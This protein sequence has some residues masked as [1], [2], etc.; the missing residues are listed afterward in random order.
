[1]VCRSFL[2]SSKA[3][4]YFKRPKGSYLA[5]PCLH[6][7]LSSPTH[8]LGLAIR[9]ESKALDLFAGNVKAVLEENEFGSLHS[10]IFHQQG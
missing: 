4:F 9:M 10:T 7:P 6:S 3:H 1:M 5:R 8:S 2:L